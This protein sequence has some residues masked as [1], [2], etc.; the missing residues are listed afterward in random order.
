MGKDVVNC[1]TLNEE[2]SFIG[3]DLSSGR[4]LLPECYSLR[5][6]NSS[7]HILLNW[8]LEGS[9]DKENWFILDRRVHSININ[10]S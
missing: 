10:Q 1:G 2:N 6:R 7:T 9:I 5:N 3:V 8:D 4:M